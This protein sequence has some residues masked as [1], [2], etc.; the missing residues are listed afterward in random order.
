MAEQKKKLGE[1]V[2]RVWTRIVD[3]GRVL[4][5]WAAVL[6]LVWQHRLLW[7]FGV[8]WGGAIRLAGGGLI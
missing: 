2:R 6:T 5:R 7:L 4:E 8:D 3:L 1:E